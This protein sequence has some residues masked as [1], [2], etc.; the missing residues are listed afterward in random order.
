MEP[1][2]LW[3]EQLSQSSRK[4]PVGAP[5]GIQMGTPQVTARGL[6]GLGRRSG[7]Y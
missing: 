1:Q 7:W 5:L 4:V 3:L 6:Q 2:V